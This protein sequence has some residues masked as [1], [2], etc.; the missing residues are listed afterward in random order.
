MGGSKMEF[1]LLRRSI[2]SI[3][4]TRIRAA[5]LISGTC[6]QLSSSNLLP[7]ITVNIGA[8]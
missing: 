3:F 8:Y 1:D 4:T 7:D 2:L 6:W 5:E